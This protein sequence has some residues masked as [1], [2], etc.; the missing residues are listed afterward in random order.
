VEE[1]DDGMSTIEVKDA[2]VAVGASGISL[3]QAAE[4]VWREADLLDRYDY[5]PWLAM[6]T[7][8]GLYVIP[9]ERDA[10]TDYAE[11][12]NIAYD[13]AAMRE[14]RVKRLRSGF[15]ISSAPAARTARTNSRFVRVAET[16]NSLELRCAQH[17]VEYK[18]ERTRILAADVTYRL[19]RGEG[20]LRL[21]YKEVRLINS[22]EYVWGIGYLM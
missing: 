11:V 20:G 9:I 12:L 18:F 8:G 10:D 6:W 16:A 15:S 2:A 22:D 21:D 1:D 5:K 13:D 14:A 17:I 3:Q 7:E 19:V 4:F